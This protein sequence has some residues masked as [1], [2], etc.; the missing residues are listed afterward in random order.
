M[1]SYS[2]AQAGIEVM[3][4][5]AYPASASQLAGLIVGIAAQLAETEDLFLYSIVS[6]DSGISFKAFVPPLA[7]DSV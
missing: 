5:S 1:V 7:K 2:V 6:V 3:D 4:S